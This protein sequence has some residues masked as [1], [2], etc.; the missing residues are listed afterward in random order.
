MAATSSAWGWA[1]GLAVAAVTTWLVTRDEPVAKDVPDAGV[2]LTGATD[3][4]G[5]DSDYIRI[6]TPAIPVTLADG[7]VQTLRELSF[8][9]PLLLLDVSQTCGA[10]RAT[11][12]K[13]PEYRQLLPEVEVRLLIEAAPDQTTLTE[14]SEPQS[15]HDPRGYLT[16]TF[17]GM[18][19]TPSALLLGGDGMLAGGPVVGPEEIGAFISDIRGELDSAQA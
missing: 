16:E 13:M 1:L 19:G 8:R 14:V 12:E 2:P 7:R 3:E 6:R 10:C 18:W 9:K 17:E 15:L 5:E 4:E 11:I